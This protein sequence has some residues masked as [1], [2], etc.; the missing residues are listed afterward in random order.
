MTSMSYLPNAQIEQYLGNVNL[1]LIRESHTVREVYEIS[2]HST[3]AVIF[4]FM[5]C[6][7][8]MSVFN[9]I[10]WIVL[11]IRY[12]SH[13]KTKLANS[14]NKHARFSKVRKLFGWHNSLCIFKTKVLRVA[15]LCS[16]FSVYSLYSIWKD[17]LY[18]I[19]GSVFYEWGL[20][21]GKVVG[22]F[23]KRTLFKANLFF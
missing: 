1:F 23:E 15:K 16:Y 10:I 2:F 19:S 8:S 18:R 9:N 7:W 3:K 21:A 11:E 4:F 14:S 5:F 20:Q 13:T 22:S 6:L 17:Q 12:I